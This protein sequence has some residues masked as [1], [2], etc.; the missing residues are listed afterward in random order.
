MNSLG[1]SRGFKADV[2]K[3]ACIVYLIEK[4]MFCLEAHRVSG[5]YHMLSY[6]FYFI[7]ALFQMLS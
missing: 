6:L 3:F 7:F 2:G 5:I 1:I 4:G